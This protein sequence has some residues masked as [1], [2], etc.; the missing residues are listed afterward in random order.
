MRT[1]VSAA[2]AD[3]VLFTDAVGQW[4]ITNVEGST[5]NKKLDKD[6]LKENLGKMGKLDS[7]LIEKIFAKSMVPAEDRKDSIR[8][9][10][11]KA[12]KAAK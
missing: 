6:K 10:P 8:V 7:D 9:T 11:P 2:E 5:G 3:T 12:K 1:A 4:T